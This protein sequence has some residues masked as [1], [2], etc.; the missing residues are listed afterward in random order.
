MLQVEPTCSPIGEW[1]VSPA[2]GFGTGRPGLRVRF[3]RQPSGVSHL[4]VKQPGGIAH[5]ILPIQLERPSVFGLADHSS[6]QKHPA[7]V[8]PDLQVP[9]SY[10]PCVTSVEPDNRNLRWPVQTVWGFDVAPSINGPKSTDRPSR[11]RLV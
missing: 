6:D 1:T 5:V 10:P 4:S 9:A 11:R 3:H 8:Q 2:G 7:E